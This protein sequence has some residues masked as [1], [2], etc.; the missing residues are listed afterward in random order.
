MSLKVQASFSAG[1]LD[2]ALTE[3][4]TLQKF[5]SGL[6]TA[7]GVCIGKTGR[8][9]SPPGRKHYAEAYEDD[10]RIVL[11]PVPH[12]GA[13]IEFGNNYAVMHIIS[14]G[15]AVH[16]ETT[17]SEDEI[18]TLQ[19]VPYNFPEGGEGAIVVFQKGEEPLYFPLINDLFAGLPIPDGRPDAPTDVGFFASGTPSGYDVDYLISR[20]V[21]GQ[22]TE[23][24]TD[25]V[26]DS[27]PLPLTSGESNLITVDVGDTT[28]GD[29][30]STVEI[31][32]YR[33]PSG[34]GAFG[35]IGASSE[36]F[37]SM[38]RKR[39]AFTDIG[40]DADYTH[41]PPRRNPNL[42]KVD[43]N[44]SG[45]MEEFHSRAAC[46]YKQRLVVSSDYGIEASRPGFPFNF[47]RDFPY[48]SDSS[49]SLSLATINPDVYFLI[50][51]DG[52]I[53]FTSDGVYLH[54]GA[55]STSNFDFDQKGEW[56]IDE[57][58]PPVKVPGGVLFVDSKTNSVR[59]L[60]FSEEFGKYTADEV[61]IFS[62]HLFR[63]TKVKSWAFEDGSFPLLW[64][65]FTDG[66]YA[67]FTYNPEQQMRAWTRHDAG[68]DIEYVCYLKN[69]LDFSNG[70]PF[71]RNPGVIAFVVNNNGQRSI[72]LGIDRYVSA[73]DKEDDLEWDKNPSC[74]LM[75][76]MVSWKSALHDFLVDDA[77]Q[78]V[79]EDS[80]EWDGLLRLYCGNDGVFTIGRCPVGAILRY[81][82]PDDRTVVDLKVVTRVSD[83][84]L[85]VQPSCSF[86]DDK[87]EDFNLYLTKAT[88]DGLD[89]MEGESVSVVVDGRVVASPNNDI[90]NYTEV[91]VDSGAIT[92]PNDE[93]GAIVHVGRPVTSDIQTLDIATVEQRPVLIESGTVNKLYIKTFESR[94]LYVGPKFPADDKV[95]GMKKMAEFIMDYDNPDTILGNRYDQPVSIR[96]EVTLP[97]EWKTNG[98]ICLR[99]VDPVHFEILSIIPDY[100]DQRR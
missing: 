45:G 78:V 25:P 5:D 31:R 87:A 24:V 91:I 6:K 71:T 35:F 32:V 55:M 9:V 49:F 64:V 11:H 30:D 39:F 26:V 57:F 80:D 88:F 68:T 48:S 84:E 28:T 95:A 50:E 23:T 90:E 2:E 81:F 72:E 100:E 76:S 22:E 12:Y 18:D 61:S 51:N 85:V 63:G 33:R 67:S 27:V 38:G 40:Q 29:A 99:N 53:A 34:A 17:W 15:T 83:N 8:L 66:T 96:H 77:F 94:G 82:N 41:T 19:I 1:E 74:A 59:L 62:D 43:G 56:V 92:L 86:P 52:L 46:M 70:F 14:T 10:T 36:T 60:S 42:L 7:R 4:T 37:D 47:Y 98:R 93:V 13:I 73:T 20:F 97:G 16:T 75:H 21:N 89:H 69:T 54:R 58:V 3:R 44:G 65:V 79:P